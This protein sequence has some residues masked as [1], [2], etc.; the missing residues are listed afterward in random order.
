[1]IGRNPNSKPF[2]NDISVATKHACIEFNDGF[3]RA[4]LKDLGALNGCYING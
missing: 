2:I 3:T 1:M 4:Y